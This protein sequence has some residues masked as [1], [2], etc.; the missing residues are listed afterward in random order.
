MQSQYTEPQVLFQ[1]QLLTVYSHVVELTQVQHCFLSHKTYVRI[2][3]YRNI[4]P[5]YSLITYWVLSALSTCGKL[6]KLSTYNPP[7][8]YTLHYILN[9]GRILKITKILFHSVVYVYIRGVCIYFSLRAVALMKRLL[10]VIFNEIIIWI[11]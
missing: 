8:I 6:L 4:L 7:N 2:F 3:K 11:S 1:T 10:Y 9:E 5:Q